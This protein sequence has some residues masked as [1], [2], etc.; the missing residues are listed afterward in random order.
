MIVV[1]LLLPVLIM[2][3]LFGLDALENLLFPRPE[4]PHRADA[5]ASGPQVGPATTGPVRPVPPKD[6][7]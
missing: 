5:G 4:Q 7:G 3:M 6:S 2:L 1:A